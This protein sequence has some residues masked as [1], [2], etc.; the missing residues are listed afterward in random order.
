MG[1]DIEHVKTLIAT[2]EAVTSGPHFH[3]TAFGR[4]AR[5]SP[6]WMRPPSTST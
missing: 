5:H 6:R 3:R 1:V 2:L 4:R